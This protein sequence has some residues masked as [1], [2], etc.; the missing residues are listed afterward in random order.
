VQTASEAGNDSAPR[1]QQAGSLP[2]DDLIQR[3]REVEVEQQPPQSEVGALIGAPPKE[4]GEDEALEKKILH[5]L[6][7]RGYQMASFD[8]LRDRI[9]ETLTDERIDRLLDKSSAVFRRAV[10]KGGRPGL[11]KLAP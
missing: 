5:Y 6:D 1:F 10:L 8:R 9:D 4:T 11:A 3:I 2:W 7:Q